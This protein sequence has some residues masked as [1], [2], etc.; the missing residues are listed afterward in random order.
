M[1]KRL[2]VVRAGDH[3]GRRHGHMYEYNVCKDYMQLHYTVNALSANS[4]GSLGKAPPVVAQP[5]SQ[6]TTR[7]M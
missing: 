6:S 2:D 1:S 3:G 4:E 7:C 5:A